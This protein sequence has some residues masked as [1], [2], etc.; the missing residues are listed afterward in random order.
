MYKYIGFYVEDKN[1][2][3]E[4]EGVCQERYPDTITRELWMLH[5]YGNG[6]DIVKHT[7]NMIFSDGDKDPW[8]V[9]GVPFNATSPDGSVFHIMIKN[10]AH[11]QDLR[12]E[13]DVYDSVELKE[14]RKTEKEHI[15]KW[16]GA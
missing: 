8:S 3:K 16:L 10:S 13:D 9:G 11:H 14:A 6:Q 2:I 7:T 15:A 4:V 5:A 12:F 1:Q